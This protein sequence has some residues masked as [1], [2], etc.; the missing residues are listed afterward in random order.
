MKW[1]CV[2]SKISSQ[3]NPLRKLITPPTKLPVGLPNRAVGH[4]GRLCACRGRLPSEA[5]LTT[6]P[7]NLAG[8]F[9]PR[10]KILGTSNIFE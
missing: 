9:S 1:K 3:R 6:S 4:A 7:R 2:F 8:P 10:C 5:E